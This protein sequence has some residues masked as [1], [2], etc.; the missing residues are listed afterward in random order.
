MKGFA[1]GSLT[2]VVS[3]A[4]NSYIVSNEYFGGREL[5]SDVQLL[6]NLNSL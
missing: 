6:E 4:I 5:T 3:F 1:K 2:A